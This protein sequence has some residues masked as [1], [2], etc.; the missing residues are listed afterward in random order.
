MKLADL[1]RYEETERRYVRINGA[2]A[3]SDGYVVNAP[4]IYADRLLPSRLAFHRSNAPLAA[5]L[6][7]YEQ[8]VVYLPPA[9]KEV[10]E[11]RLG[12]AWDDF[13]GL[14]DARCIQPIIGHPTHYTRRPY[15]DEVFAFRP[16]SVWARGDELARR[17]AN[18]DE[19]WEEAPHVLPLDNLCRADWVRARF[20]K[21]FPH[22][23]RESF[24]DR[25]KTEIVTNYV[26]LCIYGYGPLAKYLAN[27]PDPAWAAKRLLEASELITYPTLMGLGGTANYGLRSDSA[28]RSAELGEFVLPGLRELGPEAHILVDGL[29]LN[30][31]ELTVDSVVQF[32]RDGMSS[33]LWQALEELETRVAYAQLAEVD[34]VIDVALVAEAAVR[35][36]IRE[37]RGPGYESLR[38]AT[39][40]RIRPWSDLTVK[41]GST[42]GLTAAARNPIGLDWIQASL[43]GAQFAGLMF[44]FRG[45]EKAAAAVEERLTGLL[46]ERKTSRLA[47]QLWWLTRWRDQ[48]PRR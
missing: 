8:T 6:L 21:Q 38:S 28:A 16:P 7:L 42:V 45:F 44:A 9:P 11:A 26:D 19:Y 14:V 25:V 30:V 10:L 43:A 23:S 31:P 4:V 2:A 27:L 40:R 37:V 46:V 5:L 3:V 22:L 1:E 36:M 48:Q 33:R 17:F 18:A 12:I 32:H 13:I 39:R 34:E 47:T 15:F 20:R 41:L 24:L 29:G 35:D